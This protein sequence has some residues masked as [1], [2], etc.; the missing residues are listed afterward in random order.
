MIAR[1]WFI[2]NTILSV[3]VFAAAVVWVFIRI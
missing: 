3:A 1:L 2:F